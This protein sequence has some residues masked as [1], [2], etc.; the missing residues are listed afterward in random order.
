MPRARALTRLLTAAALAAPLLVSAAATAGTA[1]AATDCSNWGSG[2]INETQASFS[3]QLTMSCFAS[4]IG[5]GRM[6]VHPEAA[7][8]LVMTTGVDSCIA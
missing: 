7:H 4:H 6:H 1:S 5:Y 2:K 3:H 8:L